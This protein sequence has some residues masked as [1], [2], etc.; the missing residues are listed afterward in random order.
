MDKSSSGKQGRSKFEY[1]SHVYTIEEYIGIA[2]EI[3][4]G[5]IK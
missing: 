3:F 5:V 2:F 1:V 4:I